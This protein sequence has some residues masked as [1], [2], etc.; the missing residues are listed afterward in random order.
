MKRFFSKLGAFFKKRWVWTLCIALV[1]A[2]LVWFL[3]PYFGFGDAKPWESETARLVTICIIFLVWGLLLVFLSWRETAREKKK[4][5]SDQAQEKMVLASK[6]HEEKQAVTSL[7]KKAMQILKKS[8][9][10]KG[11]SQSWKYDLPWYLLIGPESSGKTSLLDFSGLNFPL[12][13]IEQRLTKNIEGTRYCDWYFA[14][15]GIIVDTCGRYFSQ[16][17]NDIDS[18]GWLTLLNLL[19][20]RKRN[21]P[22]NGVLVNIPVDD[23]LSRDEINLERV[24]RQT[25]TRLHEIQQRLGTECPVYVLFSKADQIIGFN[26]FFDNLS[27][28]ESNQVLGVTFTKE[29]KVISADLTRFEFERLLE[30]LN[31]Q[32]VNNL[33]QE[34][35]IQRRGKILDFPYQ[36]NL[37]VDQ[38]CLFIE[39]ATSGN[40][41]QEASRLRGFYFMSAPHAIEHLD[42]ST[43]N[44][45]RSLGLSSKAL[46][47]YRQGKPRFI[48]HLFSAVI[49]PESELATLDETERKRLSWRQ[50]SIYIGSLT[51]LSALGLLWGY[52]FSAN[53]TYLKETGEFG[54]ELQ[55][56][57]SQLIP[58]GDLSQL[59]PLLNTAYSAY[60][61]FPSDDDLSMGQRLGL[62]QGEDTTPTVLDTYY[63]ELLNK[64]LPGVA[65]QLEGQIRASFSNRDKLLDSL[66]AYLM[67][68]YEKYRDNSYLSSTMTRNWA[69]VYPGRTDLQTDLREHFDRLLVLNFSYP[70]DTKLVEQ[71]R[72]IL[73]NEPLANLVYNAMK[74]DASKLLPP[75]NLANH[76]GPQ[77]HLVQG[78]DKEIPG[79]FTKQ[80]YQQYFLTN[81]TKFI[82]ETLKNNWVLGD[83]NTLSPAELQKLLGQVE[84]LYFIDYTDQ[85][86]STIA[87]LKIGT[88]NSFY[89]SGAQLSG[90]ASP[91][92]PLSLLLQEIKTHTKLPGIVPEPDDEDVIKDKTGDIKAGSTKQVAK[93]VGKKA[94]VKGVN[95]AVSGAKKLAAAAVPEQGK[96]RMIQTF[97]PYHRLLQD[98]DSNSPNYDLAVRALNGLKVRIG[99][100]ASNSA[101]EQMALAWSKDRMDG[102]QEELTAMQEAVKQLPT[103]FDRWYSQIADDNWRLVL[104]SAYNYINQGYK[105]NVYSFYTTSIRGRYP[106]NRQSSTDVAMSDFTR[107][108]KVGGVMDSFYTSELKPF[109]A[110]NGS[111]YQVKTVDGRGLPVSNASLAQFRALKVIQNGLFSQSP[112]APTVSFKLEPQFLEVTLSRVVLTIDGQKMEYRHGPI[113]SNRFTWPSENSDT[114]VVSEVFEDLSGNRTSYQT[115]AGPWSLFRF[116]DRMEISYASGR[117]VM[118]LK[119]NMD[120]KYA[121]YL[122][123]TQRSPNPFDVKIYRAFG[124]RDNL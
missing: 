49:F 114:S 87:N 46:P 13:Q 30:R 25:R 122:L 92:S 117:D 50:R 29:Q 42:R 52:S 101:P 23:L 35:D 105:A 76:L 21:R 39:L 6:V 7:Y 41:Y 63:K 80:G 100:M 8:S 90:L 95:A 34:R 19:R 60:K 69:N 124:L 5:T 57:Q 111:Y 106:F 91:T 88:V 81:G 18:M 45:G 85:W 47:M 33:H 118:I 86:S 113:L 9:L 73:S 37:L 112:E 74:Q 53:N 56:L 77:G 48:H 59:Q 27:Q 104:A 44:I 61:V 62:Y 71:A 93:Q 3:F 26:E 110:T 58:Q 120:G 66:R 115:E 10:Y 1:L 28:E 109:V 12:N 14:E 32:V 84:Q 108:F 72:R 89:E 43:V 64:M 11:R 94:A 123:S 67:L 15:N 36:F 22:I 68:N 96:K 103:P 102:K 4:L 70:L 2:L 119:T 75:Y 97:T 99:M 38:L 40:R 78:A 31:K 17:N 20:R 51:T 98:D 107:F 79:F 65:S 121:N 83:A 24:A 55:D 54:K 82:N 16:E 116:I